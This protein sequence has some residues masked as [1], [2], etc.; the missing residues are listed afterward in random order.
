DPTIEGRF[1]LVV[2]RDDST[3]AIAI[4]S[5]EELPR[6]H[7][8]PPAEASFVA[9]PEADRAARIAATAAQVER[10]LSSIDGV[11]DARVLLDIPTID[12][13][14]AALVPAANGASPHAT[15][16]VLVRHRGANPPVAPDDLRRLVAGA[17]TGLA[18][19]DVA[20]VLVA[21]PAPSLASDRQLA[22]LGPLAIAKSSLSTAKALAA[23]ILVVI[24]ALAGVILFLSLRL[25]RQKDREAEP[26]PAAAAKAR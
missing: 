26:V 14:T 22:Y 19:S 18:T 1:R 24:A 7:A 11:L 25:R 2:A 23:A 10:T 6:T 3:S 20:V 17:V 12:P 21:V 15:A 9:S 5:A 8:P 13:L 4:L 16:S